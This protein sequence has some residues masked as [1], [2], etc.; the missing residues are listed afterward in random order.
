M[1]VSLT[2]RDKEYLRV[3][4][5]LNGAYEPVGPVKLAKNMGVSKECAYQ[6]MQRLTHLGY[7][8]YLLRQG[9]TLN[10]KAIQLIQEDIKRHHILEQFLQET[11]HLSHHQACKEATNMDAIASSTLYHH[12]M[13]HI[14]LYPS[15]CCG[16]NPSEHLTPQIL[17][18][19]PWFQHI[20]SQKR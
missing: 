10:K 20:I 15:S 13:K 5:A 3:I 9:F 1:V 4:F 7:G 8:N 18:R 12:L 19:C 2:H 14:T 11:L 16:Y 17:K 6:K